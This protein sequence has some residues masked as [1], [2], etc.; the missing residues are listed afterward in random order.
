MDVYA[1]NEKQPVEVQKTLNICRSLN[2]L[3]TKMTPK[4]FIQVFLGSADSQIAYLRRIWAIPKGLP[5]TLEVLGG[6]RDQIL[7]TDG[8]EKAWSE[9]IQ[10]EAIKLLTAQQPPRGYYPNGCYHSSTTLKA[11]VLKDHELDMQDKALTT[12]HMPFLYNIILATLMHWP[13][14]PAQDKPAEASGEGDGDRDA[15]KAFVNGLDEDD[16]STLPEEMGGVS[17]VYLSGAGQSDHRLRRVSVFPEPICSS[18]S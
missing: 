13:H 5:S 3:P 2:E 18:G 4:R 11:A 8:G 17:Y 9:F 1:T 12:D 15:S 14:A 10:Q 6:V 16:P 7:K